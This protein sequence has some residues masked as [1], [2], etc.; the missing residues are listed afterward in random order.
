MFYQ[1]Y[2]SKYVKLDLNLM[3]KKIFEIFLENIVIAK[4]LISNKYRNKIIFI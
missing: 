4:A 1:K 3:F 2:C